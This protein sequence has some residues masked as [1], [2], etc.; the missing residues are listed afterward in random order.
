MINLNMAPNETANMILAASIIENLIN[1][2]NASF[3]IIISNISNL[4][5]YAEISSAI[6]VN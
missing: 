3:S 4:F 1:H 6:Q 5:L 2:K